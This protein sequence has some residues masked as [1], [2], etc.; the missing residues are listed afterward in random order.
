MAKKIG[1]VD[2]FVD[3]ETRDVSSQKKRVN[4]DDLLNKIKSNKKAERKRS[5]VMFSAVFVLVA[6]VGIFIF[7]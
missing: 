4:L 1:L 3:S 6:V 5:Y 7:H 2:T